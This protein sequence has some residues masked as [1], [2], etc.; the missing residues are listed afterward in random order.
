M[1]ISEL[2]NLPFPIEL[3]I[4]LVVGALI[5]LLINKLRSG[6]MS[7]A[8]IQKEMNDYKDEVEAHFEETSNKF[9]DMTAQYQDLYQHL[10]KGATSLCR[11][12]SVAIG[13]ANESDPLASVEDKSQLSDEIAIKTDGKKASASVT[14]KAKTKTLEEKAKVPAKEL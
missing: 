8:N 2:Q 7:P 11:P 13:L 1:T 6:S 10:S 5:V 3:L 12:E 14:D 4:G 9:K